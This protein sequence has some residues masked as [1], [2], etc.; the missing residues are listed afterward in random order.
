[1]CLFLLI[2]F[3]PMNMLLMKLGI[4][5]CYTEGHPICVNFDETDKTAMY[6]SASAE[7]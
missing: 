5:I 2:A 1:M 6:I 4:N 7:N 3:G